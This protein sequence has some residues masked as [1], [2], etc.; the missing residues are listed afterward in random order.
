M[1]EYNADHPLIV[2]HIPKT[3]G[4]SCRRI[5]QDWFGE[6]LLF[7]YFKEKTAEM[8]ER[9]D[10]FGLHTRDSPVAVYGHFNQSRKFGVEHYYPTAKQ[11]VTILRDPFERA[12]SGYFYLRKCAASYRD[13][14][15]IPRKDL[16]N[17]L[18][19]LD[20]RSTM[21]NHFPRHMTMNNYQEVIETLFVEIGITEQLDESM[22]RIALKLNRPYASNKLGHFNAAERDQRVPYDL[23]EKFIENRP[24]EYAVYDYVS[25]RF[26]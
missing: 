12:V 3:A 4:V 21:L 26:S 23:K 1:K 15:R 25:A 14:T 24:L 17:Y 22:K 19:N 13:Q 6:K 20:S 11:F 8:P 5:Y 9:H 16:R 18:D 7:H 10:I 2:L